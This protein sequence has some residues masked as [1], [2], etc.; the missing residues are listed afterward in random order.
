MATKASSSY[1]VR[2]GS[3]TTKADSCYV[4]LPYMSQNVSVQ[5]FFLRFDRA[6]IAPL[7]EKALC[8]NYQ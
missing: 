1:P 3:V 4:P 8:I 2:E 7:S 5:T 6:Y